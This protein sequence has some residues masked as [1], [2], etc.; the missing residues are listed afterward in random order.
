MSR[1][2]D[3]GIV[4]EL[5]AKLPRKVILHSVEDL[6]QSVARLLQKPTSE[7]S[8]AE[9]DQSPEMTIRILN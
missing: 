6:P 3:L 5:D 8:L 1:L 9:N 7:D 2:Q 4:G